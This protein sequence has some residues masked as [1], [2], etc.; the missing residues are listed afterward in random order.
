MH[1]GKGLDGAQSGAN[2]GLLTRPRD[3]QR[4]PIHKILA[5]LFNHQ[6]HHGGQAHAILTIGGVVEPEPL[7]LFIMQRLAR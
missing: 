4:Q 3:P 2:V 5:R 7:D 6:T 1:S